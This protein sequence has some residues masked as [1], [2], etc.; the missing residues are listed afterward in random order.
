MSYLIVTN[1][2]IEKVV[3]PNLP[4]APKNWNRQY[5][6]QFSNVLRLYFNRLDKLVGQLEVSSADSG[7]IQT[8]LWLG[9]SGGFFSG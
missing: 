3:A 7:G 8:Q 5:Q 9:N 1:A 2:A 6:D 4:L